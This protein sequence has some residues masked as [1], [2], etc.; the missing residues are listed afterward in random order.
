MG[1]VLVFVPKPQ[2]PKR[3]PQRP[4]GLGFDRPITPDATI[5]AAVNECHELMRQ[6]Q[7]NRRKLREIAPV[8]KP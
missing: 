7:I 2:L 5:N 8:K 1:N 3:P 4:Q 6:V